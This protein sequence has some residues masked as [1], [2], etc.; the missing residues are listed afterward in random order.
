MHYYLSRLFNLLIVAFVFSFI[1]CAST[2]QT[3]EDRAAEDVKAKWADELSHVDRLDNVDI[4]KVKERPPL[5]T[6]FDNLIFNPFE[7]TDVLK[8]DY[9]NDIRQFETNM[10]D[11]LKLKNAF[12]NVSKKNDRKYPGKTVD[13]EGKILDMRIASGA[14]RFWGGA[15]AGT[16]FMN[17]Y[18]KLTDASTGKIIHQQIITTQGNPFAA[19]WTFGASDRNLPYDMGKIVGEYLFTII[20][21]NK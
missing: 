10:I 1:S 9:A 11:H 16:S 20:P 14:A 18:I 2:P 3:P 7:T 19:A 13:I 4:K 12:S 8:R 5:T 15:L 6:S 17:I 21:S